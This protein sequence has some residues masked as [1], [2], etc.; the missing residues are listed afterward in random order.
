METIRV[1]IVDDQ[2]IFRRALRGFLAR[3]DGIEVVAEAGDGYSAVRIVEEHHPDVV[4][5]D[6]NMPL[7][8]GIEA[9]RI[10]TAKFPKTSVIVLSM[11]EDDVSSTRAYQAGAFYYLSKSCSC[12]DIL[13]AVKSCSMSQ[14]SAAGQ[15]L[16]F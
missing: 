14:F 11:G 4:L 12:M 7:R 3:K 9:T 5:M 15:K 2:I 10:I 13:R 8:D 16:A 6:I 1:A